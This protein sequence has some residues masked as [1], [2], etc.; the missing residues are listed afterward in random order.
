M[1]S[2]VT[3]LVCQGPAYPGQMSISLPTGMGHHCV[4][5]SK[6]TSLFTPIPAPLVPKKAKPRKDFPSLWKPL[7]V[8]IILFRGVSGFCVSLIS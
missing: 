8:V 7:C 4:P 2:S 1:G 6:P 5:L 3:P